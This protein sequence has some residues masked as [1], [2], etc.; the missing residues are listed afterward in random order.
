MYCKDLVGDYQQTWF[1]QS[2]IAEE[3]IQL[4]VKE[5]MKGVGRHQAQKGKS[6]DA[7][8]FNEAI[9]FNKAISFKG[10]LLSQQPG[11]SP[12]Q[13]LPTPKHSIKGSAWGRICIGNCPVAC[14]GCLRTPLCALFITS[15]WQCLPYL[16]LDFIL[17]QY[18]LCTL[19]ET[20]S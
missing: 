12:L 18:N 8:C 9:S 1:E 3:S 11:A 7:I 13:Y 6:C 4:H 10:F 14:Y 16:L 17:K 15:V 5:N 20:T 2:C 19:S